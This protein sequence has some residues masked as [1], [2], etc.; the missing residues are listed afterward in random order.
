MSD[1][2]RNK[3]ESMSDLVR[4]L[5]ALVVAVGAPLA[6][7]G[8]SSIATISA[9]PTWYRGLSKPAWNPPD[10]VFGPAW[11][12]LYILMGVAAWLVWRAGWGNSAVKVALVFFAVQLVF[13]GLWTVL[14]F[15]LRSPGAGLVEIIILWLLIVATMVLF[16]RVDRLAGVLLLPYLAWVTFA[17]ALNAAVWSLNR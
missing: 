17:S 16:F 9:I 5:V 15:G 12:V 11:T 14:F 7:G 1:L 13:N 10:W 4:N 3:E 8:I 6:V 2:V